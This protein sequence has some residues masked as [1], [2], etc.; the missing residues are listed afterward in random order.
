MCGMKAMKKAM[1]RMRMSNKVFVISAGAYLEVR[2]CAYNFNVF[3]MVFAWI[4]CRV[5]SRLAMTRM[6]Y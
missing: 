3:G 5:A 2:P 1:R 6:M 4:D